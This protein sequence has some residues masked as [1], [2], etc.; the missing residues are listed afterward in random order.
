MLRSTKSAFT[1]VF[2]ALWWC[3]ADPGPMLP[4]SGSRLCAA[5]FH[6]AARPGHRAS[7][8]VRPPNPEACNAP[9]FERL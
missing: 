1:R 2:D 3:A 5:A 6:A 7:R 4:Q 8:Y 9:H